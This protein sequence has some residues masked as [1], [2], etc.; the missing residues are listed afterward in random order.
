MTN[1]IDIPFHQWLGIAPGTGDAL[2]EMNELP[3]MLNHVG[4]IHACIQLALAEAAAGAFLWREFEA[5]TDILV[6]VVRKTEAKYSKPANGKLKAFVDF[7]ECEKSVL[8]NY[9]PSKSRFG[10]QT[11]VTLLNEQHETTLIV[12]F[13]WF[14][15]KRLI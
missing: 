3:H 7:Y 15:V 12:V 14:V 11:R 9:I 4:S 6:P 10:I 5:Y 8:L 1:I 13:D 2:L